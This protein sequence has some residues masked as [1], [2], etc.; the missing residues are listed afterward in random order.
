LGIDILSVSPTGASVGWRDA[1]T[2]VAVDPADCHPWDAVT[3]GV[4]DFRRE[5]RLLVPS[6][7]RGLTVRSSRSGKDYRLIAVMERDTE[8][9]VGVANK[10]ITRPEDLVGKK[11]ATRVG[12][13]GSWFISEYLQ[14]NNID[15]SQVEIINL[16]TQTMPT[17]LCG[18]D[19]AAFFVWQPIGSRTLAVKPQPSA[20][21]S[22][23]LKPIASP[24]FDAG[25]RR[26]AVRRRH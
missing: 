24:S 23:L 3:I 4:G 5:I 14:K 25:H 8:G 22:R 17:A 20:A 18:G 6:T 16:D 15:E 11:I 2:S 1:P 7:R 21:E 10:E 9:Y 13:T 19:I 12:S 26:A